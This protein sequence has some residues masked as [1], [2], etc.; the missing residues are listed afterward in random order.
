MSAFE[1]VA[2]VAL[3]R[4]ASARIEELEPE[5]AVVEP[6]HQDEVAE[7]SS[8]KATARRLCLTEQTVKFHLANIYRKTGVRNRTQASRWA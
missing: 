6:E 8:N 2:S 5:L 1:V 7:G 4:E 3:L